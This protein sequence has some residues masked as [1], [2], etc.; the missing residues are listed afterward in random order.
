MYLLIDEE[1]VN[2]I[3]PYV[4]FFLH[5]LAFGDDCHTERDK[6]KL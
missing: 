6:E 1:K 5:L 3:R 2:N 4:K